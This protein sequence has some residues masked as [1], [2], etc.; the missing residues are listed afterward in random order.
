MTS[1]C[2]S[3]GTS[4]AI[5]ATPSSYAA[6]TSH[7]TEIETRLAHRDLKN[8]SKED[9]PTPC[10]IVDQ[11]IFEANIK[12]MADHCRATGI[13]LRGHVKVHK[14]PEIAKRQLAQGA[15]GLTC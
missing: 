7:F 9:L 8:I 15:I 10:M 5:L 12:K 2:G 14:S 11:D 4:A 6:T 1:R 3:S 13:Q